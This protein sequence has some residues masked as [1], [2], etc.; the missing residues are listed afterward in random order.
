MRTEELSPLVEMYFVSGRNIMSE[1][2]NITE[3]GNIINVRGETKYPRME[4][5]LLRAE[6]LLSF[7]FTMCACFRRLR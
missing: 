3:D 6:T 2:T 7:R 5:S 1:V 4:T